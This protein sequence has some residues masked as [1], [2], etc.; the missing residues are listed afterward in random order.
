MRACDHAAVCSA[1]ANWD[2][3]LR[4]PMSHCRFCVQ[5][6]SAPCD[7]LGLGQLAHWFS[8][9][10]CIETRETH[11]R[12]SERS[13][14]LRSTVAHRLV[15]QHI[16]ALPTWQA[17][18]CIAGFDGTPNESVAGRTRTHAAGAV[19][20]RDAVR[21]PKPSSLLHQIRPSC[22]CCKRRCSASICAVTGGW[23]TGA[24]DWLA[25]LCVR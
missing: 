14:P 20:H 3:P 4:S 12:H 13:P 5:A 15:R 19:D 17:A 22:R 10:T 1:G 2:G 24:D 21:Q 16:A 7:T 11:Q 9:F 18:L 23:S 25:P 6:L 8:E